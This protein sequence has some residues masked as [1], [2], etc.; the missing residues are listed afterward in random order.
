LDGVGP[1]IVNYC[2]PLQWEV[3]GKLRNLPFSE[4][5]DCSG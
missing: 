2:L 1:T 4:L 3:F 5:L